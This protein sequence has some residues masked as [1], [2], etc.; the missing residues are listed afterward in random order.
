M[1][2]LHEFYLVIYSDSSFN[3]S[4]NGGSQG[5]FTVLLNDKAVCNNQNE[6]VEL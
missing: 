4:G 6:S 2:N 5:G 1:G 3:N